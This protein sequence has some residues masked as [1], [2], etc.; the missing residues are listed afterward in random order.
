M[1]YLNEFHKKATEKALKG[2]QTQP[3][4]TSLEETLRIMR[5][6]SKGTR[7]SRESDNSVKKEEKLD[8]E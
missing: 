8:L 4:S 6:T 3:Q 1:E 2:L 7:F 5:E